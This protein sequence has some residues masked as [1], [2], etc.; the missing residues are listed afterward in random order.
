MD[1]ANDGMLLF[2]DFD[3]RA[4]HL[5]EESPFSTAARC[6]N[7]VVSSLNSFLLRTFVASFLQFLI[8]VSMYQNV[9]SNLLIGL[10]G[11][12]LVWSNADR[13]ELVVPLLVY[14]II[15]TFIIL[16]GAIPRKGIFCA[17]L[18]IFFVIFCQMFYAP[19]DFTMIRGAI[20]VAAMKLISLAFDTEERTLNTKSCDVWRSPNI[21]QRTASLFAFVFNPSTVLFGPPV[22]FGQF[23]EWTFRRFHPFAPLP[24]MRRFLQFVLQML[25][26]LMFLALSSCLLDS[27]SDFFPVALTPWLIRHY[28]NAQSFRFS[29]FFVCHFASACAILAGYPTVEITRWTS[30]E[31]PQSMA[32]V[33]V[34]WNKPMHS[35]LHK[36]VYR[37]AKDQLGGF[38]SILLTFAVSS[39]LHGLDVQMIAV[40]LSL[41]FF[42]FSE[43]RLRDCLSFWLSAC[44]RAREC[45]EG[46]HHRHKRGQPLVIAIR[47]CFTLINILLLVYLGAPFHGEGQFTGYSAEHLLGIWAGEA[48]KL[49]QDEK[50]R[51]EAEAV[52]GE[53]ALI[54]YPGN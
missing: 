3:F 13:S 1:V 18:T 17:A 11:L 42:A 52:K 35:F 44:V 46:C 54:D 14:F 45:P 7:E 38:C 8:S 30:I 37:Q 51:A 2:D 4:F 36:Y 34:Y 16:I 9:F 20:M 47:L 53:R 23:E 50:K 40:L 39:A 43:T 15:T 29:H 21:L 28:L 10:V 41:G 27:E 32:D 12:V 48:S 19:T 49:C 22:Q 25:F 33:V 31:W 6:I 26:S 5:A 24:L